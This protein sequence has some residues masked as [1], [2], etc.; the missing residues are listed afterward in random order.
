MLTYPYHCDRVTTSLDSLWDFKFLGTNIDLNTIEPDKIEYDDKLPVP[1]AFDAF[2]AYSGLR[3]TAAYRTELKISPGT[4]GMIEFQSVG[5]YCMVCVDGQLVKTH[6]PP[7]IPFTCE[8][9]AADNALR[10]IVVIVDNRYDA[11]RAPLQ[12][13]IFDFYN[14]GGILRSVSAFEL[15]AC[16]IESC[17]VTPIDINAGEVEIKV[18]LNGSVPNITDL[19][20]TFDD[21][22]PELYPEQK[23]EQKTVYIKTQVPDAKIWSPDSPALHRLQVQTGQDDIVVRFGLREVKAEN[24][25]ILLNGSPVKLLGFCRHEAHPQFGPALPDAQLVADI[26]LLKELG[27]NFVRGSHYPQDRRFLDL[28]DEYGIMVF[29]ES[30]GWGPKEE[31]F[32]NEKFVQAQ[33]YQT[34][35]MIQS[36]YNHPCIIMRGFLNEGQSD[37]EAARNCYESLI[38]LIKEQ[39]PSRLVT[40]ASF[41]RRT[42]LFLDQVDVICYNTYPGWYN[43]ED[44][45]HPLDSVLPKVRSD[46][47]FLQS[48]PDLKD[49]PFILSE[50]GAGA[51]YGWHDN[52][53]GHWTEEYQSELLRIVC[54]EVLANVKINGVSLWQFCDCRTYNCGRALRRPRAFNN[55]GVVDE[56]RR[57]KRAFFTVKEIFNQEK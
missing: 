8:I 16:Y 51:I 13:N 43:E 7:Y 26:Q 52:M 46:V 4:P 50:I 22:R 23:V 15:P 28:C 36:S 35:R 3:G 47:E 9:P 6:H 2:P 38:N 34:D 48:R 24:H 21:K 40:Y 49:K 55:K 54:E 44:M 11:E 45:D 14:Y 20:L 33:I 53:N 30:L 57:P 5:I 39:D 29:D 56:Y 31:H 41:K 32:V 19:E 27:C 17:H 12:E 10:E 42:D 1:S 25:E 18:I 37:I